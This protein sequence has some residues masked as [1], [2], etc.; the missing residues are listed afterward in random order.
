[1]SKEQKQKRNENETKQE[2]KAKKKRVT[3]EKILLQFVCLGDEKE[4]TA[5]HF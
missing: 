3:K 1:M 4:T 5:L 2:N